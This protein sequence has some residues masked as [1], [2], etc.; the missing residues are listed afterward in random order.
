[1]RPED[2]RRMYRGEEPATEEEH[3][4]TRA[5]ARTDPEEARRF[6][7]VL[8]AMSTEDASFAM[9]LRLFLE[10]MQMRLIEERAA[11]DD[12][13]ALDCAKLITDLM[14]ATTMRP[15]P[16]GKPRPTRSA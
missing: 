11:A 15:T 13:F 8:Y 3:R 5:Q 1:M 7:H 9:L 2:I 14:D 4:Q 12:A 10:G 6:L 16:R